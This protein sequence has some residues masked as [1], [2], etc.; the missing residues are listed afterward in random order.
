MTAGRAFRRASPTATCGNCSQ[1]IRSDAQGW[2]HVET[3]L[4]RCAMEFF[5]IPK[6]ST[7]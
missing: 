5:A 4:A 1:P 2:T 3:G 6:V 7:A